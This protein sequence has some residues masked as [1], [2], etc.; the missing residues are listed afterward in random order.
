[1]KAFVQTGFGASD[2]LNL[3][4]IPDPRPEPDDVVVQVAAAALNRLDVLQRKGP[5]LLPGFS[6][7]HIAGMDIAGTVVEVGPATVGVEVGDRVLVNPSIECGVCAA[8]RAGDDAYC[9]NKQVLGGNAPGG[10]AERVVVPHTHVH[11]IP[12]SVEFTEAST[13]PTIHSTA[14][15]ALVE[16]GD[17]RVG[18]W[19]LVHAA[20]SGVSTAAIQLAQRMGARVIATAGSERKL[21]L[22]LEL[23]AEFAVSNRDP[24]WTDAVRAV[25]GGRGVDMVFDHVGPAL[26]DASIKCLRPGG[27]LVFCG[28]TTGAD[29]TFSLPYAYQFGLRILGSDT[30]S[31]AEFARML[32]S[33]WA[34]DFQAV[35]DV[36]LPLTDLPAAQDRLDANDVIGKIV[37]HP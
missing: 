18:E 15:G 6:L 5:A 16:T 8:C 29:A 10:F 33:Y 9:P 17:L 37:L 4:D 32:D 31:R 21:E 23:G 7:P 3:V 19:M 34:S 1:L 24:G 36:E 25:T 20:A 27:R 13:I 2:V 35:V 14:W 12:D 11:R 28:T 26:F 22:A 30:Y